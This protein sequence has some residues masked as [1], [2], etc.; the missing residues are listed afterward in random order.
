MAAFEVFDAVERVIAVPPAEVEHA[1][2]RAHAVLLNRVLTT[3]PDPVP[4]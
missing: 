2:I 4:S 3:H 1:T